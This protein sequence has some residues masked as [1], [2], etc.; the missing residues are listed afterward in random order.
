MPRFSR[1]PRRILPKATAP[2][3]AASTAATHTSGTKAAA[4]AT[5]RPVAH[6]ARL[7]RR[8]GWVR[9]RAATTPRRGGGEDR[10]ANPPD[11]GD[12]G[13]PPRGPRAP[14]RYRAHAHRQQRERR[15]R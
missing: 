9:V 3:P 1:I 15:P 10:G 13:N 8:R 6:A 14:R 7:A 12:E 4:I 5:T 11:R 2:S